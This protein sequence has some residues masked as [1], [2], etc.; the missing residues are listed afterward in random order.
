M[1]DAEAEADPGAGKVAN[2]DAFLLSSW[3]CAAAE[4][5]ADVNLVL[6]GDS[7][8]GYDADGDDEGI[9][10]W[11]AG[12][13]DGLYED[14]SDPEETFSRREYCMASICLDRS[15]A[16]AASS[17][18]ADADADARDAALGAGVIV[19]IASACDCV[20]L[21]LASFESSSSTTTVVANV[22]AAP[23]A[24]A[25]RARLTSSALADSS[26]C[27]NAFATLNASRASRC[28]RMNAVWSSKPSQSF[29]ALGLPA[30]MDG[31]VSGSRVKLAA[32][33]SGTKSRKLM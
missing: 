30:S 12:E 13:V 9:K 7:E 2:A 27:L 16:R 22:F 10:L 15:L 21:P 3:A 24:A 32:S 1:P 18:A 20:Q 33:S 29:P 25:A 11:A 23:S 4:A 6:V 14:P 8:M 28:A 5:D 26:D 31:V 17:A 19:L